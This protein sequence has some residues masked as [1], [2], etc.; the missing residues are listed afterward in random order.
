MVR[1]RLDGAS[2]VST[3]GNMNEEQT[4]EYIAATGGDESIAPEVAA[5]H[6]HVV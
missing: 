1:H 5:I 3:K 2:T 6:I 4:E